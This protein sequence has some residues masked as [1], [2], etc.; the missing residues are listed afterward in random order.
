MGLY[1]KQKQY[2]RNLLGL[3]REKMLIA[4][5]KGSVHHTALPGNRFSSHGPGEIPGYPPG[6]LCYS[7]AFL[8]DLGFHKWGLFL[9]VSGGRWTRHFP[10][11]WIP[12]SGF[13]SRLSF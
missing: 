8:A 9:G 6:K 3:A 12:C 10:A 4:L 11:G 5:R 7:V 2:Q 13:R 1:G